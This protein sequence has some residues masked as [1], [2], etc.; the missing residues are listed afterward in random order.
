M[1]ATVTTPEPASPGRSGDLRGLTSAVGQRGITSARRTFLQTGQ[2][3]A[4]V[5]EHVA[6]SWRRSLLSGFDPAAAGPRPASDMQIDRK[7]LRAAKAVLQDRAAVIG[8]IPCALVLTDSQARVLHQVV[9][10]HR[11]EADLAAVELM[12]GRCLDEEYV[13]SNVAAI[14][15]ETQTE[16]DL[17][18]AE[19]LAPGAVPFSSAGVPIVHPVSK[20][21]L[22]TLN[23]ITR[24][25][26]S[27]PVLLPW[28]REVAGQIEQQV[29]SSAHVRERCLLDAYLTSTR[30]ARHPI[31]CL[32][33]QTVLSNAAASR[34]LSPVDQARLWE[35]ASQAIEQDST[36]ISTFVLTNGQEVQAACQPI[37]D[38]GKAVGAK[39]EITCLQARRRRSRPK[40]STGSAL[41][42]LVGESASWRSLCEEVIAARRKREPILLVG[43]PGTGKASIAAAMYPGEEVE[44][45]DAV[46]QQLGAAGE[47]VTRLHDRLQTG[48]GVVVLKHLEALDA[49]TARTVASVL[50]QFAD[51][52]GPAIVGTV[53]VQGGEEPGNLPI[54]GFG[55]V[56]E[57]PALRDR[58]EDLR[59][60][61]AALTD[62][63]AG[64]GRKVRWMPDAIQSL[65]RVDLPSNVRTLEQIVRQVLTSPSV[66]YVDAR[67]LPSWVRA[68]GSRR[69]LSRLERLEASAITAALAESG[70]NKLEAANRLG[71]ARSTLYRRLT[72]LGIDLSVSNF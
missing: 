66:G 72:V 38:G 56:I 59:L 41:P 49:F 63:L 69:Q 35:E 57:T 43:E 60:L 46:L 37:Y 65:A 52:A 26:D 5:R 71:I 29:L 9:G 24:L 6:E 2:I 31:V 42:P 53:T 61:L 28:L 55:C 13:G 1:N 44:V 48:R 40:D 47:W 11:L 27:S 17:Y 34:L 64:D 54:D 16:A 7:L 10:D 23:S 15:I 19:H 3:S 67:D 12:P 8:E 30:T 21:L 45:I 70:G 58:G 4:G 51:R 32:D 18:G 62:R 20:R 14:A 39:I 22:G 68:A 50:A 25:C 33:Q 36:T